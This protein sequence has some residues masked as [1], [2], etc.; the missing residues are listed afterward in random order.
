MAC[1]LYSLATYCKNSKQNSADA[2]FLAL[3]LG[4]PGAQIT[5]IV[6]ENYCAKPHPSEFSLDNDKRCCCIHHPI[7]FIVK[8]DKTGV[9]I[10]MEVLVDSTFRITCDYNNQIIYY[11]K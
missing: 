11:Y 10:S 1:T 3:V 4:H 7:E 6:S 9:Y 2:G 8:N 5:P